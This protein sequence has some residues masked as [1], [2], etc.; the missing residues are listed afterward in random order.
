[1]T[2]AKKSYIFSLFKIKYGNLRKKKNNP[3]L[4]YFRIFPFISDKENAFYNK[5]FVEK[6]T[7][8]IYN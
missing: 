2:D 4:V 7:Y 5:S 8:R 1:M 6:A 3:D